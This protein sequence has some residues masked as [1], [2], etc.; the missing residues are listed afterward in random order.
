LS[1]VNN[2]KKSLGLLDILPG[3]VSK[4]PRIPALIRDGI[5]TL[6]L[7]DNDRVS[8]GKVLEEN[9]S[10]Y[11]DRPAIFFEDMVWSHAGFN[12]LVNRYA[13]YFISLGIQPGQIVVTFLDNRPETLFITAALAKIG[14]IASLVNSNQR[15]KVLLH[16]IN[17]RHDGFFAIGEELVEAF[18]EV[19][20]G[21][22]GGEVLVLLGVS[23]KDTYTFP[24][25]YLDVKKEI[26]SFSENN[27]PGVKELRA[28]SAFA[29]IFTSGTT[30]MPKASVQ[31]NRKWIMCL[32]WFGRINLALK[33]DDVIYISI[34]FFHANALLVAWSCAAASGAAM[35]IR[36]KFSVTDF[37]EDIRRY[38][39]SSFIYIGEIC[40]YLMNNPPSSKDK[41]HRVSKIIGNGMRPD[42]WKG[43]K[44]RFNIQEVVEFY[45]SSD[46]NLSFANTLNIEGSVGWCVSSY[47][48][49]EFDT[50]QEEPIRTPTGYLKKV[51][52][53]A[54]GLMISEITVTFPFPGYVEKGENEKKLFRDVFR[55]GDT[56]FNTGDLMR[57]IGFQHAQFVDR[58]GDTFRWKGENVA[59]AE[60]EEII[61]LY[62][63]VL[64]SAVYGV[65]IPGTEGKAG[66]A[67][68][69]PGC[70]YDA[71]DMIA[72]SAY[73]REEL[74]SFAIPV[75]L[76]FCPGFEMTDTHKIKKTVLKKEGFSMVSPEEKIFILLPGEETYRELNN[77]T[78]KNLE[79]G[80]IG[81]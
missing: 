52:T 76:R 68:I 70:N 40:R 69:V 1:T 9:A 43:F 62:P 55:K 10:K 59:T 14:A 23:D 28:K 60:V 48:I 16:S 66:M 27:I 11:G 13:R 47:A 75:F 44:D 80:K 77:A 29:Y 38:N 24:K 71:F 21:I 63:D 57:D 79:L 56:W 50:E 46:G 35:A 36:R 61:N 33:S 45:A 34:P 3:M 30:G 64:S 17:I 72:F 12:R 53:G 74:P 41:Q 2:I 5:A 78:L 18:E 32:N 31:T 58:I 73:L 65:A 7:R 81:F 6:L 67:T 51:N 42:I 22:N 49:V 37:W 8:V 26:A 25:G 39:A 4:L 15:S 20:Q 19:R 54:T